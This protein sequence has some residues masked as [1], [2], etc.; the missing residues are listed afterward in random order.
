M[1]SPGSAP[2]PAQRRRRART[3]QILDVAWELARRDGLAAISLRE[4]A[5]RVDMRQP[6]LYNYFASKAAL[7]DAMFAEGF[8]QL[9]AEREQLELDDDPAVALRQ[10]CRHFVEF[11]VR[12]PARHQLLF[13]HSLTGFHPSPASMALAEQALGFLARWLEAAGAPEPAALDLMRALLVGLAG[14]QIANEP[15][16]RRWTQLVDEVVD[17]VL[18]LRRRCASDVRTPARPPRSRRRSSA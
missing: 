4:L 10:G 1:A 8:A 13:Q 5:D 11:C 2:T 16:G 3:A 17:V 9:V 6:S 18:E 14:E 15:E 12:D 7:Y